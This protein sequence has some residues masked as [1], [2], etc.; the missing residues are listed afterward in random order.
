MPLRS[1]AMDEMWNIAR[2][3]V[4]QHLSKIGCEAGQASGLARFLIDHAYEDLIS[5]AKSFTGSGGERQKFIF[6]VFPKVGTAVGGPRIISIN[7][8]DPQSDLAELK[9][10]K[11][12]PQNIIVSVHTLVIDA[13]DGHPKLPG[14]VEGWISTSRKKMISLLGESD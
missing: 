6:A 7:P 2:F 11:S 9:L 8:D 12:N 4:S 14:E 10:Q 13:W 3:Q 5:G 1:N